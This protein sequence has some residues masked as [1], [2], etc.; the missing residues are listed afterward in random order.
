M[1]LPTNMKLFSKLKSTSVT[2]KTFTFSKGDCNLSFTLN[3]EN[4][5]E[6]N[7]FLELLVEAQKDV[8]LEL[9]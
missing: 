2:N 1:Q 6:L 9:N 7:N 4:K 3:I 5:K 8:E